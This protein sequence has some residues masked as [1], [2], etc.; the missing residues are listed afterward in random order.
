MSFISHKAGSIVVHDKGRKSRLLSRKQSHQL[1]S[2]QPCHRSFKVGVV[3]I[4]KRK[5]NVCVSV[6]NLAGIIFLADLKTITSLRP[7][8]TNTTITISKQ[9]SL[10][11][12]FEVT[13]LIFA[14]MFVCVASVQR[15]KLSSSAH[16]NTVQCTEHLRSGTN[17]HH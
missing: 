8:T 16:H 4:L 15:V 9:F 7:L 1:F 3:L 17:N 6:P 11:A 5:K 13:T 14:A 12:T 2:L 10:M